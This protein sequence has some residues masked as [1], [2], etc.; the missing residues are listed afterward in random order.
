MTAQVY[1]N[2][3]SQPVY[4]PEPAMPA[5]DGSYSADA[6]PHAAQLDQAFPTF[7]P[8]AN[9]NDFYSPPLPTEQHHQGTSVF[10]V[11]FWVLVGE[12]ASR[13]LAV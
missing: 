13:C 1:Q 11:A 2:Y 12:P 9:E 5:F 8:Q 4:A 7:A 10:S 6:H 3:H